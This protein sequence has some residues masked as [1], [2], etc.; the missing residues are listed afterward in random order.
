MTKALDLKTP[1]SIRQHISDISQKQTLKSSLSAYYLVILR[2]WPV[3]FWPQNHTTSSLFKDVMAKSGES[4]STHGGDIA[5]NRR[6]D[7]R[8]DGRH[9]NITP[10]RLTMAEAQKINHITQ[11]TV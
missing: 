4:G 7:G 6:T 5:T 10:R 2:P 1:K 9:K 3:T 11:Q 8:M